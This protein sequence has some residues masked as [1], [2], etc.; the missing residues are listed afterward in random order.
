MLLLLS[1]TILIHYTLHVI[2]QI[3]WVVHV[4]ATENSFTNVAYKDLVP[5]GTQRSYVGM[6][7]CVVDSYIMIQH[8]LVLVSFILTQQTSGFDLYA[9]FDPLIAK[10]QAILLGNKLIRWISVSFLL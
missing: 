2:I 10:S 4:H 6:G 5:C 3:V 9:V 7:K 8:E 1:A